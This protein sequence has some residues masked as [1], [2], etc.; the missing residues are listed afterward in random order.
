MAEST[1]GRTNTDR[2][3]QCFDERCE[4]ASQNKNNVYWLMQQKSMD[5]KAE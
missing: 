1:T 2:R 4:R 3:L 5:G